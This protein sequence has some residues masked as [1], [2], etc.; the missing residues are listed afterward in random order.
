[1]K[2]ILVLTC[3][4]LAVALQLSAAGSAYEQRIGSLL[5]NGDLTIKTDSATTHYYSSNMTAWLGY[6]LQI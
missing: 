2:R 4:M 6:C 1:M 3:L 5:P